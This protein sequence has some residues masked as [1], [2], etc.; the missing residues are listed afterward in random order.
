[1]E[2]P[3]SNSFVNFVTSGV[4][5]DV[6]TGIIEGEGEGTVH[7]EHN[8]SIITINMDIIFFIFE[9][10]FLAIPRATIL[11]LGE[12]SSYYSLIRSVGA[13]NIP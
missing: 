6:V 10:P 9:S 5:D 13:S 8:I 1:M 3:K 11:P 4:G 12:Y 2:Y 7:A